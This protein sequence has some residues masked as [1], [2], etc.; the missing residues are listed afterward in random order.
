MEIED[1]GLYREI[2][3]QD[4]ATLTLKLSVFAFQILLLL[5]LLYFATISNKHAKYL[6]IQTLLRNI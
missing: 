2:V 1:K 3:G 6:F 4:I 5:L